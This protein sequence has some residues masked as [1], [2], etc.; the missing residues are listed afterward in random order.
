[1]ITDYTIIRARRKT[2]SIGIRDDRVIVRAPMFYQMEDIAGFVAEKEGWITAN[3]A[4]SLERLEKRNAF[5]LDYGDM[6]LYRGEEYPIVAK[7]GNLVEFDCKA[8]NIP[9]GL[10]PERVKSACIQ[11]YRVLA[12]QY[13]PGRTYELAKEMDVVPSMVKINGAKAR[14]GS[15]GSKKIINYSW[16][17]IMADDDVIDYIIA[18]ELSHILE[19]NHSRSF[20]DIVETVIPDYKAR[21]ERL[22]LLQERVLNEDWRE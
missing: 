14:W 3:L 6:V 19:M 17:L 18:H 11:L 12:K 16:M 9:P 13:L 22:H 21:Q 1:M 2:I 15:C 5:S 20:W 8:F 10:T 7:S 4:K